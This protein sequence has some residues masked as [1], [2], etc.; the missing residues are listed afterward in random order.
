M[1]VKGKQ[2]IQ[3]IGTSLSLCRYAHKQNCVGFV[4]ISHLDWNTSYM[5]TLSHVLS[6][7]E[8]SGFCLNW[9]G[10]TTSDLS[11]SNMEMPFFI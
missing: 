5:T 10:G 3:H 8:N 4:V 9:Y 11:H 6:E 2:M 1:K 7:Y